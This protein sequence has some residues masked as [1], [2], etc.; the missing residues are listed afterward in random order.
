MQ[1][2]TE[3]LA[4]VKGISLDAAVVALLSE[5]DSIFAIKEEQRKVLMGFSGGKDVFALFLISFYKS[6][7]KL[8][9]AH[10]DTRLKVPPIR[11]PEL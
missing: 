2:V 1:E 10:S 3:S 7:V 6:L 9:M 5:P 8:I 11:S 4:D